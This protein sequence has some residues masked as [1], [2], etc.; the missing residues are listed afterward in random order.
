[1]LVVEKPCEKD[2]LVL[3][4]CDCLRRRVRQVS[5]P[6]GA[7]GRPHSGGDDRARYSVPRRAAKKNG[8]GQQTDWP[9]SGPYLCCGD[10][11]FPFLRWQTKPVLH[12]WVELMVGQ[13][14]HTRFGA[15]QEQWGGALSGCLNA[16]P[17]FQT[18][19][20]RLPWRGAD[21]TI[22]SRAAPPTPARPPIGR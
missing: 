5:A 15:G 12:D 2:R 9:R 7:K 1:M 4:V 17:E 21:A 14:P 16:R 20:L 18:T 19:Q 11:P 22:G 13:T 8:R 6:V 3:V 10:V